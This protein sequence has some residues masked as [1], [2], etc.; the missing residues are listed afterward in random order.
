M[1]LEAFFRTTAEI[2]VVLIGFVTIFLTFVMSGKETSKA[3]RMH[4]R[5]LLIT[6]FP[7]MVMPF[8]PIAAIAYG[9]SEETALFAFHLSGVIATV[10]I[11][12]VIYWFFLRMTWA[13]IKEVGMVHNVVSG[14]TGWG[15]GGFFLAGALGYAPAG[16]AVTAVILAFLMTG[17]ALFSFAAQ[18]MRLFDWKNP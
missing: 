16:N 17:T 13:E 5:A 7:L 18:Q 1:A 9:A 3:D 14:I 12:I 11:G 15:A 10:A 2:S 8:I 6:A 4:S